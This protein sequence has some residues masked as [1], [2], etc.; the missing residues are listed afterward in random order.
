MTEKGK[1]EEEAAN[2]CVVPKVRRF[3]EKFRTKCKC[4][5]LP[6]PF[7]SYIIVYVRVFSSAR[8]FRFN[9]D[10]SAALTSTEL[11]RY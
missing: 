8:F 3:L 10:F 6:S 1:R 2:K 4:K 11:M 5:S 7:G 9:A